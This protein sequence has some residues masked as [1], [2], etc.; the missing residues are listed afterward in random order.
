MRRLALLLLC[1]AWLPACEKMPV[2]KAKALGEEEANLS[3]RGFKVRASHEGVLVWEADAE[4]A[5]VFQ[6]VNRAEA[7]QVNLTYFQDGKAV[8][9]AQA[10]KADMDL[11]D[12]GIKARGN[13]RVQGRN[14]VVLT[15]SQLNW[16]NVTQIATSQAK[17]RVERKGTVLTGWGLRADRALQDVRILRDV[18][19]EAE[20]VEGLRQTTAE[21]L[22]P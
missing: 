8:S 15:T 22:K 9:W 17:V 10:D 20:S 13:V 18:Q 16:D 3:F 14:G 1:A 7:E 11:K 6:A 4:R 19:A 21:E 2:G 12:Y 5:K